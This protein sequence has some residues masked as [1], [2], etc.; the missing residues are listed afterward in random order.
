MS[1]LRKLTSGLAATAAAAVIAATVPALGAGSALADPVTSSGKAVVPQSYDV[2]SVGSNTDQGLFDQLSLDYNATIP[3][4][5]HSASH[6]YFYSWDATEPGTQVAGPKIATKGGCAAIARPNGSGAGLTALDQNVFDGKTGHYCIDFARSSSGRSAKSPAF[7]PGGVAYVA[8]AEDAVTYAV[9]DTGAAKGKAETYAPK[10]LTVAQLASIFSCRVTNWS[11]VGGADEPIHV[12]IPQSSSGTLS[13]WLKAIGLTEAGS[14]ANDVSNTLEENQ[15]LSKQFDDP[16]AIF[17]YSVADW[18]AQKYHSPL[19]GD[20][21]AKGQNL[22]GS[23]D[24]GYLGLGSVKVGTTVY[25]PV[26]TA[27][28]PTINASFK[29]TKLTRT[30]YDVVRYTSTTSDHILARLQPFLAKA[31]YACSNKTAIAAIESYGFLTEA[32]CGIAS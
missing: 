8:L 29:A 22:F 2:V 16:S 1:R 13:F 19:P 9:R 3:A 24:V 14:C 27:K 18:V 12:Y 28:V 26:T 21:A 30:I 10:S 17:I 25:S 4:K 11:K 32:S 31:G 7:G 6:P 5:E 23:D 20:K 15:G